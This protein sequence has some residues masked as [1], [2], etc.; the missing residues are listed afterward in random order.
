MKLET[1]KFMGKNQLVARLA[2]QVGSMNKA[3]GILIKRGD[4]MPDGKTLTKK[5]MERN[6]MTAG[7]R[8]IDRAAKVSKKSKSEYKYNPTTNRATLKK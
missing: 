7:E 6:K 8:A 1:Q 4:M 3:I 5:G 2:A